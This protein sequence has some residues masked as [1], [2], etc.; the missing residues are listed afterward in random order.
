MAASGIIVFSI[1][2]ASDLPPIELSLA[3]VNPPKALPGSRQSFVATAELLRVDLDL[4]GRLSWSWRIQRIGYSNPFLET[5]RRN[6]PTLSEV[7]LRRD[8]VVEQSGGALLLAIAAAQADGAYRAARDLHADWAAIVTPG[9]WLQIA[10][11]CPLTVVDPPRREEGRD[12]FRSRWRLPCR[13]GERIELLIDGPSFRNQQ[14]AA[15]S[16][17]QEWR[18]KLRLAAADRAGEGLQLKWDAIR[19]EG[20]VR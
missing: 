18:G 4:S 9:A 16:V 13:P 5:L 11:E 2:C 6:H 7:E 17:G 10:A 12:V 15:L 8:A 3:G 14:M 20:P 19:L 1:E